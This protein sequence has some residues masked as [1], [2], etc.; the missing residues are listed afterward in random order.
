MLDPIRTPELLAT[1]LIKLLMPVKAFCT[2][3]SLVLSPYDSLEFPLET[4]LVDSCIPGFA[5]AF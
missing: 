1:L 4:L 2:A 5:G 3:K